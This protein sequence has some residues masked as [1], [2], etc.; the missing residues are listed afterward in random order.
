LKWVFAR[1]WICQSANVEMRKCN[2]D[3]KGNV[4]ER[5]ELLLM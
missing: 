5:I 3:G 4:V 1:R 2:V